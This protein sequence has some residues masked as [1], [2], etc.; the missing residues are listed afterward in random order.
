[1]IAVG[2]LLLGQ[3]FLPAF[4]T[5]AADVWLSSV[6][7][8]PAVNNPGMDSVETASTFQSEESDSPHGGYEAFDDQCAVCHRGHTAVG[9][10]LTKSW[11]EETLCFG[12]HSS[13]GSATTDILTLFQS[14][15]NTSTAFFSHPVM[16]SIGIHDSPLQVEEEDL[17]DRHAECVDCH[18]PHTVFGLGQ[19]APQI[20]GGMAN[21][22]GV[23]PAY[24]GPGSPTGFT[25]LS[26]A[27]F[28]YQVCFRCH[29]SYIQMPTYFPDGWNGNQ[30]VADGL[31]KLTNL[32][33]E[34]V[35][36][37]RDLAREFNPAQSSYHPV[38]APGR[39]LNIPT[40]SFVEGWSAE[41]Y[42]Y[43]SDCHATQMASYESEGP[44]GGQLHILKE[45]SSYVTVNSTG[46][47]HLSGNEVCFNCHRRET[48]L[49][50]GD[51]DEYTNFRRNNRNLHRTHA[52]NASCYLCHDTHGS[53]QRHLL[54][55]DLSLNDQNTNMLVLLVGYDQQPTNSQTFWQ[56]SPDGETKT[57]FIS[58]HNRDHTKQ[59]W[60]YPNYTGE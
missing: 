9:R 55:L 14:F 5:K 41:R 8:D 11:P 35:L 57:C 44:H 30:I 12:C 56:V 18:N 31:A 38:I 52:N 47:S 59:G 33:P 34:Q 50:G 13:D 54:N 1:M 22:A 21:V 20:P 19:N 2:L 46:S 27:Q 32:E 25:W 60:S 42:T 3:F 43:C 16:E 4:S 39:N 58:C 26:T 24:E 45:T 6:P 10:D 23:E 48:Y 17:S 15:P 7:G 53:E 51:P 49:N 36:D 37:S 28:E 29:S 40:G